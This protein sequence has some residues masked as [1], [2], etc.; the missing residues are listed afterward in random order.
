MSTNTKNI[1]DHSSK[2]KDTSIQKTITPVFE[3]PSSNED[4]DSDDDS[5]NLGETFEE[6]FKQEP[7]HGRFKKQC[8]SLGGMRNKFNQIIRSIRSHLSTQSW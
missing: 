8:D 2:K 1:E 5:E 4:S 6:R 7:S 3:D